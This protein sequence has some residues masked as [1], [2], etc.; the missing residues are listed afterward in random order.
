M[1]LRK[2]LLTRLR[3]LRKRNRRAGKGSGLTAGQQALLITL[4]ERNGQTS[5]RLVFCKT[6]LEPI[7]GRH[8][9]CP[10]PTETL[11]F[12]CDIV[13]DKTAKTAQRPSLG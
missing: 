12:G 13:L 6:C 1:N 5:R 3:T 11:I 2:Q 10:G 8:N 9:G 7:S 4:K